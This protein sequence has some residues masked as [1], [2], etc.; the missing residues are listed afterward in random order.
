[1]M[2]V[3]AFFLI[4]ISDL[5]YPQ[6]AVLDDDRE[7]DGVRLTYPTD[8]LFIGGNL[9]VT[10]GAEQC[11]FLLRGNGALTRFGRAGSGPGEFQHIPEFIRLSGDKLIISE[12][13]H[14]WVHTWTLDGKSE[15]RIKKPERYGT[16]FRA[17]VQD[18]SWHEAS[19]YGFMRRDE[20]NDCYFSELE[21]AEYGFYLGTGPI[22]EDDS[23]Y[24]YVIKRSGTVELYER[25]CRKIAS[26]R[27]PVGRFTAEVKPFPVLKA[28]MK[29]AGRAYGG[30]VLVHGRPIHDAV[31]ES[32]NRVWLLVKDEHLEKPPHYQYV[33]E[34]ST[35]LFEVDPE[36]NQVRFSMQIGPVNRIRY[37]EG[38]L[39]LISEFEATVR[40]YRVE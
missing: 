15:G 23:G 3:S 1:M 6:V 5:P 17:G 31:V 34:A 7:T 35:W 2:I 13:N 33:R 21:K 38:H 29:A 19:D 11:V 20:R 32:K 12:W 18:L 24:L 28:I 22:Y 16:A 37:S 40:V 8:A 36:N 39:I 4:L 25:P 30:P 27:I 14:L 10:D 9:Y 26:M